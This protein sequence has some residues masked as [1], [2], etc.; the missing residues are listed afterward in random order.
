MTGL[1]QCEELS[2]SWRQGDKD[3]VIGSSGDRAIGK[4]TWAQQ[5]RNSYPTK[6]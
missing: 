2:V 5:F 4:T 6:E 1:V 3:R